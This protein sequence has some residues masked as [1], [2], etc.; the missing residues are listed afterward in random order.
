MTNK[1]KRAVLASISGAHNAFSLSLYNIKAHLQSVEDVNKHWHIDVLQQPLITKVNESREFKNFLSGLK[2]DYD[3]IAFP[4]YMW[5]IEY[6][7]NAIQALK[8]TNR[9]SWIVVGGPEISSDWIVEGRYENLLADIFVVGN[10]E[11]AFIDILK[12][13]DSRNGLD[14]SPDIYFGDKFRAKQEVSDSMIINALDLIEKRYNYNKLE[15][16]C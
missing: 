6:I 11:K 8:K 9:K 5:A 2:N 12:F 4:C 16:I 15:A 13:Y 7:K 14:L 1:K 3:V 10:G